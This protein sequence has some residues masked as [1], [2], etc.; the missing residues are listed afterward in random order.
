[1]YS[2]NWKNYRNDSIT[3]E[4]F[5]EKLT[6]TYKTD[7]VWDQVKGEKGK[8]PDLYKFDL[9]IYPLFSYTNITFS[10]IYEV[11]FALAPALEFSLWKGNKFTLQ[12]IFPIYADTMVYSDSY[13]SIR[14]GY[15]TIAQKVRIPGPVFTTFTAGIFN[16]NKW[17][18]D[19]DML[20]PFRNQHWSVGLNIGYTARAYFSE[21][22]QYLRLDPYLNYLGRVSYLFSPFNLQFDLTAGKYIYGD[23]GIRFDATRHFGETSIGFY[24]I[25]A[26]GNPNGGFHLSIPLPPAK[27]SRRHHLRILPPRYY[28]IQ[29]NGATEY[30]KGHTYSTSPANSRSEDYFNLLYIKNSLH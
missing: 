17:G 22:I 1:V 23:Y 14:P 8:N 29:Y 20:Y 11:M 15:V 9:V 7:R 27:R 4:E 26:G 18:I 28:D 3:R 13:R 5:R 30:I 19:V 10:K 24:A 25:Y 12:V 21:G 2:E 6:L 16:Q